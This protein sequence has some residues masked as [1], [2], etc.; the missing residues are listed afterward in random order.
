MQRT[1]L[2]LMA[3]AFL[4]DWASKS[5]ALNVLNDDVVPLGALSLE[6]A[7]NDAFVLSAGAG[8]VSPTFVLSVRLLGLLLLLLL[9]LS[10]ADTLSR[11][12]V[13]GVSL[14]VA[15]GLGNA[16]DLIF[17]NGAVVDFIST[18]LLTYRF[19]GEP[20]QFGLVFNIADVWVFAGVYLLWPQFREVGLQ[21]RRRLARLERRVLA[22]FAG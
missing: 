15:G 8:A 12:S 19:Y 7:R 16:A 6:V 13:I 18:G 14:L 21:V 2:L 5:W 20:V 3:A 1:A 10:R 22:R 11:R 4:M 17:R 9:L